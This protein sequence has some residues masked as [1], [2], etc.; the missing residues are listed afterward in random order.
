MSEHPGW[1]PPVRIG[2]TEYVREW[3]R[4]VLNT[5]RRHQLMAYLA[6]REQQGDHMTHRLMYDSN[7]PYA[8]PDHA[9]IVAWYPHA[10]DGLAGRF[11]DKLQV[12]IDNRGDHADDCHALDVEQNAARVQT[13]VQWVQSW[14]KLHPQG[15]EAVN[16][17]FDKPMVYASASTWETLYKALPSGLYY[18]WVA[19]WGI[20]PTVLHDSVAHQYINHGPNGEDYD[21]SIVYDD[22]LGLTFPPKPTPPP[23]PPP[24]PVPVRLGILIDTD[25]TP[26]DMAHSARPVRSTDGGKTW[27]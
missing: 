2:D 18:A 16:G 22:I 15:L 17:W 23:P 19:W 11:G 3:R 25:G 8:I 20:G 12:R 21:I 4:W 7:H 9:D 26:S 13:A 27:Q 6:N 1:D 5:E 14:H 24:P 10:W